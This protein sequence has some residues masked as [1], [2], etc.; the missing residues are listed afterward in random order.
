MRD[1]C[2]NVSVDGSYFPAD[3]VPIP[4]PNECFYLGGERATECVLR[5]QKAITKRFQCP[6]PPGILI[7]VPKNKIS[8]YQYSLRINDNCV[9][10]PREYLIGHCDPS[11]KFELCAE[12]LLF[13]ITV[14]SQLD[15]DKAHLLLE[16]G[17]IRCIKPAAAHV[18][19]LLVCSGNDVALSNLWKCR[20]VRKF[21][22]FLRHLN[23]DQND[24]CALDGNP[25]PLLEVI[26]KEKLILD[27]VCEACAHLKT[28][29]GI[30]KHP[31][32][33]VFNESLRKDCVFVTKSICAY[34]SQD[35]TALES[36]R[37]EHQLSTVMPLSDMPYPWPVM[38]GIKAMRDAVIYRSDGE[39]ICPLASPLSDVAEPIAA[40]WEVFQPNK[41][42]V[43]TSML[44]IV[45][46][47]GGLARSARASQSSQQ[48]TSP[49][50]V[51][52]GS[53]ISKLCL[54]NESDAEDDTRSNSDSDAEDDA[55]SNSDSDVEGD[56]RS[57]SDSDVEG[58][59]TSGSGSGSESDAVSLDSLF[60]EMSL[61]GDEVLVVCESVAGQPLRGD[62]SV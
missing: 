13:H 23:E 27:A 3:G 30:K 50:A 43:G 14:V 21:L 32:K 46:P 60:V 57:N 62:E 18:E 25:A 56:T 6:A 55:R 7:P 11:H 35:E 61:S 44:G 26:A 33:E 9:L 54:D 24:Q 4:P 40:A 17:T 47:Q 15:Y 42:T 16:G 53:G 45:T 49:S 29:Q 10:I 48:V 37:P 51:E 36:L 59:D 2:S 41:N 34:L 1:C 52:T 22:E 19:L 38:P 39:Y 20:A 8:P 58:D 31:F 12:S 28:P 5:S